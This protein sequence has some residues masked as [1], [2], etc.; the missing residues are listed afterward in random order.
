MKATLVTICVYVLSLSIAGAQQVMGWQ[1]GGFNYLALEDIA[2]LEGYPVSQDATSL[3]VQSP[4]GVL[5]VFAGSPDVSWRPVSGRGGGDIGLSVPVIARNGTW[6]VPPDAVELLGVT[7]L[8][9]SV[10]LTDGKQVGVD[11]RSSNTLQTRVGRS[12]QVDL[13][14]SVSAVALYAPGG[15]GEDSVSILL[16]D[17]GMLSLAFPEQRR[18]FDGILNQFTDA[19]PLFFSVTAVAASPW[20]SEVTFQQQGRRF[21]ATNPDTLVI[22]SGDSN[23]VS[24]E[25]PVTG[26]ILLPTAFDLR[27]PMNVRWQDASTAMQFRQ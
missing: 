26:V 2:R 14:N 16:A 22:L 23:R 4:D 3:S 10:Q 7:V 8:G 6:Y 17:M 11:Y 20:Q 27:R 9:N 19:R 25:Q 13:G 12:E 5:V 24:P 21:I 1:E 15:A 18:E